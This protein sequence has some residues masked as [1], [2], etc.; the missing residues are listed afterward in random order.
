M[1]KIPIADPVNFAIENRRIACESRGYLGM[2]QLG[3][4][5]LR[6]LYYAHNQAPQQA[7]SPRTMRI[8]DRGNWEEARI[9]EDLQ[10]IGCN[11]H[12]TQQAISILGGLIRGHADGVVTN[13][14]TREDKTLLLEIKTMAE[15]SW[16]KYAKDGVKKVNFQYYTQCAL[17]SK[18]LSL[19]GTLFVGVNK[20]TEERKFEF[21]D[22]DDKVAD[23]A[24]DKGML[25]IAAEEPPPKIGG[26]DYWVCK[27]CAYNEICHV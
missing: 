19:D 6:N 25:V 14:P 13:V 1:S 11:V 24:I 4:S 10:N 2:S 22:R 8:W 18:H 20:N 7:V 17:Y 16:K 3:H 5:C 12:G 15:S 21:L 27:W 23:A 9:I 26:P